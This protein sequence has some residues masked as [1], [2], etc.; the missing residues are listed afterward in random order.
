[1]LSAVV[2]HNE[3]GSDVINVSYSFIF[4]LFVNL[5]VVLCKHIRVLTIYFDVERLDVC[6]PTCCAPFYDWAKSR[7]VSGVIVVNALCLCFVG[8]PC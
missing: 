1:M 3:S 4:V 5:M 6:V 8:L 2:F 7:Q